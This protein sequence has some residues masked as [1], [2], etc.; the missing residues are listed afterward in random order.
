ETRVVVFFR[1]L[2]TQVGGWRLRGPGRDDKPELDVIVPRLRPPAPALAAP[3]PRSA[4]PAG[5]S[6]APTPVDLGGIDRSGNTHQHRTAGRDRSIPP[7]ST[8]PWGGPPLSRRRWA[9]PRAGH[10]RKPHQ[11]SMLAACRASPSEP[12]APLPR[13]G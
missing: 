9:A 5:P 4:L 7:R 2:S 8:A 6:P 13:S 10:G 3:R 11:R 1:P 12:A